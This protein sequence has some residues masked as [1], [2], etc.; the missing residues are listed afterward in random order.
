MD[1]QLADLPEKLELTD[2]REAASFV[3]ETGLDALAVNVG[4]MHLHGR[5]AVRLDLTRL[6][7]LKQSVPVPLVLHG[8]SSIARDDL[9]EAVK[10]GVRKVNVGSVLK[11]TYLEALRS[12]LH[13]LD[14]D[15]NPYEAIGSG[16][17][18]DVLTQARITL[19]GV[20]EDLM[21]LFGSAGK[22]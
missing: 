19:Q 11:R 10:L 9:Q 7:N 14:G 6:A 1:G 15:Y 21:R 4:Q 12:S 22:G 20:V 8:A 13:Q 17:D 16:L 2:P 5:Q 3:E 18:D